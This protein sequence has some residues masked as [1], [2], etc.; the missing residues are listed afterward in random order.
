MAQPNEWCVHH[1][2]FEDEPPLFERKRSQL[3]ILPSIP[4]TGWLPPREYVRFNEATR[5]GF[6][7]EVKEM[8]FENG[9]GWSRGQASIV[10]GAVTLW[11][12]D[13]PVTRYY[14]VGHEVEPQY[15]LD[16]PTTMRY[17][18]DLLEN[19]PRIP[20][21]CA[22]AQ[23][24]VGNATDE[25]IFVTGELHDV[26][27][28]EA[29]LHESGE[30]N[31]DYLG[32]KYLDRGKESNLLYHWCADA[33]GGE[34]NGSQRE[35]IYRA[36]PRLVGPYAEQDAEMP[37]PILQKQFRLLE[38]EELMRVYNMEVSLIR[39]MVRIR[40]QGVRVD[41]P[42][43]QELYDKLG[44]EVTEAKKKI[45]D[46]SGIEFVDSGKQIAKIFDSLSVPYIHTEKGNPSFTKNWLK[47]CEHPIAQMI[48][49]E[50][51]LEDL[52]GTFIGKYL[53]EKNIN[54]VIHGEFHQLR[55]DDSGTR[56][57]RFS[58]SNPN[59]Q[60]IPSRSSLGKLIRKLF[61][62]FA[63]HMCW[64]KGDYSQIEYR[65]LAH[66]AVGPGSDAVRQRYHDDPRTDYHKLTQ[67][68]VKESTGM[69]IPRKPDEC[70]KETGSITI[71]EYNFGF[72]YGMGEAKVERQSG[73]P[74]AKAKA[75]SLAYHAGAP[76]VKPT[77]RAASDL[78]QKQGYVTTILGRRS[79]FD[80][81]ERKDDDYDNRSK[82][83]PYNQA[84][85]EYGANIQ[86]AM[87]YIALNR[88]LQGSAGEIFKMGILRCYQEGI[89]DVIGVPV[90][91]VHD[92]TSQSV[93]DDTPI[94]NEAY[95]RKN[96]IMENTLPIRV[97]TKFEAGR[98]PNW[99]S[100]AD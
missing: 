67:Q 33:Y 8:D 72:I 17:F 30:I 73:L 91:L 64:E 4:N 71:K 31:L 61:I 68:L 7:F 42:A 54:G 28:A 98:G 88:E 5:I 78:A 21:I 74:P 12:G 25:G 66:F 10:G 29:L 65:L 94:Q 2:F 23:Y 13:K 77:M 89:Y 14:P 97:P 40:M 96:W 15:N 60:N 19:T 22:N 39:L 92:E 9:P 16:R 11:F 51:Q 32:Q 76:Y 53:L 52:R 57:G 83:L 75:M 58:A 50:R 59:L 6:D 36:S 18:K 62:P 20:K 27:F 37:W 46:I 26:L 87:T 81:W 63:G 43:A 38:S 69:Y 49:D 70:T 85:R 95:E 82:P 93:I 41:V 24:D 100:I 47:A 35:N 86:R 56:S 80:M 1:M 3:R 34:P 99:G 44:P 90:N 55:N 45:K 48:L 84:I 79:R